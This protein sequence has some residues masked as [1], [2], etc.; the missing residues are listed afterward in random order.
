MPKFENW[1]ALMATSRAAA[2]ILGGYALTLAF[3][4]AAAVT[5]QRLAHWG[6]GEATITAAILAFGVYLVGALR[7]FAAPSVVRAWCEPLAAACAL[8]MLA[9]TLA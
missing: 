5:L 1:A 7:A 2:A 8:A 9:A 4:A 3:T 6:R